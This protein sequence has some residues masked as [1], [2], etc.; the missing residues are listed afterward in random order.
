M[1]VHLAYHEKKCGINQKHLDHVYY[2]KIELKSI[3]S[4][5]YKP[6]GEITRINK[7]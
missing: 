2:K 3:L 7:I 5:K 4:K 1:N 6:I